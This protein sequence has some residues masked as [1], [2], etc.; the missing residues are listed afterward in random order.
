MTQDFAKPHKA[1]MQKPSNPPPWLLFM[2]GFTAGAFVTF[3]AMLWYFVAPVEPDSQAS[4]NPV[5]EPNPP[6]EEMEWEFYEIF[7]KSVVPVEEYNED[8]EKVMLDQS[9]WILQVGSFRNPDDADE[10]RAELILMGFDVVTKEI[11]VDGAN[12]HRVIVG[13]FE[14][15][16]DRNRAQDKLAQAQIGAIPMKILK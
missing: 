15:E 6:V 3:L 4:V 9:A 7:P 11:E 8:G 14:A 16:L 5:P 10:L 2:T 12:W 13:P 1:E